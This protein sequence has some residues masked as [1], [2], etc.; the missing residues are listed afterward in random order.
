MGSL[1]FETVLVH[2]VYLKAIEA[3]TME[4]AGC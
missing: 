1:T 4:P 3:L 2:V